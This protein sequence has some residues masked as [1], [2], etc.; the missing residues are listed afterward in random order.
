MRHTGGI[1]RVLAD[2]TVVVHLLFLVHVAVGGFLAL[3]WRW[4]I[5][6]HL[7]AVGWGIGIVLIGWTCPLT[8]LER[9]LRA[10][11][12]GAAVPGG[13]I[14]TYVE[15]VVYPE[16][17]TPYLRAVVALAIVTSWLLLHRQARP[18]AGGPADRP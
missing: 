1:A 5:W 4:T 3:R 16:A 6:P 11:D 15:D 18:P 14:D 8:T 7:A 13:F 12:G 17:L 2:A 9:H 10:R